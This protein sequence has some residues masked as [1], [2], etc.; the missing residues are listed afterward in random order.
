MIIFLSVVVV[1]IVIGLILLSIVKT[2]HN[3]GVTSLG[4]IRW[5]AVAKA[6]I[7]QKKKSETSISRDATISPQQ[8]RLLTQNEE[9]VNIAKLRQK[10]LLKAMGDVAI[11]ERLTEYERRLNP[12]G[13]LTIWLKAVVER[14]ED[15]HEARRRR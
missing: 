13:T 15:D 11:V 7:A 10:L 6:S 9:T 14:W 4:T 2:S 1:S 5:E 12:T 3:S 8:A